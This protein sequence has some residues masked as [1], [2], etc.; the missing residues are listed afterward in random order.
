M[1]T[2]F[3]SQ[4]MDFLKE[5]IIKE[6]LTTFINGL[7]Q[8]NIRV[9]SG[10]DNYD[11]H[12]EQLSFRDKSVRIVQHDLELIKQSHILFA[13][14][15]I[16]NRS[17]VG[18]IGEIIYAFQQNIPTIIYVGKTDNGKRYWLN[19]HA[20]FIGESFEECLL[21]VKQHINMQIN[22]KES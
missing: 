6:N 8:T 15:S 17:Y 14:L 16:P 22:E 11:I 10:F 19:Y 4:A 5:E 3:F 12:K 13:D 7:S 9:V 18:A 1:T 21:V 20:T 2:I